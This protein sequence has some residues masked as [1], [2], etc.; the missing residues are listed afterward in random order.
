MRRSKKKYPWER[1]RKTAHRKKNAAGSR[2]PYQRF[3]RTFFVVIGTSLTFLSI[4]EFREFIYSAK[5][6]CI[7]NIEVK[8]CTYLLPEKLE[9]LLMKYYGENGFSLDR[10]LA[11]R[12]VCTNERVKDARVKYRP[13]RT[14]TVEVE[15]YIP[16]AY[17]AGGE[18]REVDAT[19][20]ILPPIS[21]H[22]LR[23]LPVIS[24]ISGADAIVQGKENDRKALFNA[25]SL[26]DTFE[27]MNPLGMY[28]RISEIDVSVPGNLVMYTITPITKIDMGIGNFREKVERLALVWMDL[29]EKGTVPSAIDLRYTDRVIVTTD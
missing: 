13:L 9:E 28:Q 11:A 14:L 29:T 25:L 12:E 21:A 22:S 8:G 19:G 4:G 2:G 3:F 18:I 5:L 7:E 23:N 15:E 20:V 17:V 16:I 6:F 26:L 24:G 27:E 10:K 1:R